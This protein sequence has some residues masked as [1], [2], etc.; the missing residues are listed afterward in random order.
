MSLRSTLALHLGDLKENSKDREYRLEA[1]FGSPEE[2]PKGTLKKDATGQ[3]WR[4]AR[5]RRRSYWERTLTLTPAKRERMFQLIGYGRWV[6]LAYLLLWAALYALRLDTL[7]VNG[8]VPT[9]VLGEAI[10][11]IAPVFILIFFLR[12]LPKTAAVLEEDGTISPV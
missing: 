12:F 3:V 5:G 1:E 9:Y 10:N 8:M 2:L 6:A 7:S 4:T 11:S